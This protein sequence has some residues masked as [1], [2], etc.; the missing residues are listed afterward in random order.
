MA[1]KKAIVLLAV[2]VLLGTGLSAIWWAGEA[3]LPS[4]GVYINPRWQEAE[5]E[6]DGSVKVEVKP[7]DRGVSA[8]EITL[9]F[10]PSALEVTAVE[11]GLFF[12]P[13]PLVGFEEIDKEAGKLEYALA[14]V[15]PTPVP[16]PAGVLAVVNFRVLESAKVG[17]YQLILTY[18]ALCDE[19]F[20]DI[21]DVEV[22]GASIKVTE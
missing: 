16:S 10:D 4:E 9:E 6:Q 2:L 8:G 18:A 22:Q 5:P 11:P 17:S 20:E 3:G 13:T 7:G 1:R 19:N 15:G 21:T 12:G 14:R